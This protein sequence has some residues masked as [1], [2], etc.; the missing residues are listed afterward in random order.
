MTQGSTHRQLD[1]VLG[2]VSA[3]NAKVDLVRETLSNISG[4][5]EEGGINPVK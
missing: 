2:A 1:C 3:V 5:I 4:E